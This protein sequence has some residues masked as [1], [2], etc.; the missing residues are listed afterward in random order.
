MTLAAQCLARREH[1][2]RG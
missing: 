1:G 2:Q